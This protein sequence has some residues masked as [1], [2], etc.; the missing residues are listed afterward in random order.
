MVVRVG[1]CGCWLV[2]GEAD[3]GVE[4][5]DEIRRRPPSLRNHSRAVAALFQEERAAP[6]H[7]LVTPATSR[8]A[9][10]V[11]SPTHRHVKQSVTTAP[12]QARETVTDDCT[13]TGT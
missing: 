9:A 12:T 8:A 11:A 5:R 4:W 6:F 2:G 7:R 10:G 13:N 3:C 1:L